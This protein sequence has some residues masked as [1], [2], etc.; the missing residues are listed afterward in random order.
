MPTSDHISTASILLRL[1][2]RKDHRDYVGQWKLYREII[3][4]FSALYLQLDPTFDVAR[5]EI[6]C[7]L[8]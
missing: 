6:A 2:P 5:F 3:N 1:K 8:D 7:G 4:H